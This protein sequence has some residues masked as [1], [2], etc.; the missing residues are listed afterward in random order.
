MALLR[1]SRK[2]GRNEHTQLRNKQAW[3]LDLLKSKGRGP[4]GKSYGAAGSL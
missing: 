3:M 1:A 2:A 4:E